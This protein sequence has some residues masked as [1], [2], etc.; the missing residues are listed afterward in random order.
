MFGRIDGMKRNI[1]KLT[2]KIEKS[3]EKYSYSSNVILDTEISYVY[4]PRL[5]I[6]KSLPKCMIHYTGKHYR[7]D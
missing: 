3:T 6:Q 4:K 5:I 2:R 7:L 1:K